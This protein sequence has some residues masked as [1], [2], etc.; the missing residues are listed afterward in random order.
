[1]VLS[2]RRCSNRRTDE[3]VKLS[4][5]PTSFHMQKRVQGP[6]LNHRAGS[7][8]VSILRELQFYIQAAV[9]KHEH[10]THLR[11]F[12]FIRHS[13]SS[14]TSVS[15]T[16]VRKTQPYHL[17]Q[18]DS[19]ILQH[20][21]SGC[22]SSALPS[23]NKDFFRSCQRHTY[24]RD[25]HFFLRQDPSHGLA[26]WQTGSLGPCPARHHFNRPDEPRHVPQPR[27]T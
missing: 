6:N 12:A 19:S 20:G 15:R 17:S 11:L 7:G 16:S 25:L 23:L 4:S 2:R 22:S 3:N 9:V 24:N 13:N 18:Q 10:R 1:M 27:H 8:L 26:S 14:R 5:F 21:H